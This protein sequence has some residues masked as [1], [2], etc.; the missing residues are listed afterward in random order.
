MFENKWFH[1][2][3]NIIIVLSHYYKNVNYWD[4]P[5]HATS[6]RLRMFWAL[7]RTSVGSTPSHTA[8]DIKPTSNKLISQNINEHSEFIIE[9]QNKMSMNGERSW[10]SIS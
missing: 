9:E 7:T 5:V 8:S 10:I 3:I 1:Q 2:I 6:L 4:T